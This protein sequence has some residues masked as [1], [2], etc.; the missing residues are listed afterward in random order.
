MAEEALN[1][2]NEL[3]AASFAMASNQCFFVFFPILSSSNFSRPFFPFSGAK[4]S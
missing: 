1:K 4:F 3:Y 2:W